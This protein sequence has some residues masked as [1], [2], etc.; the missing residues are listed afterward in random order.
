M[1]ALKKLSSESR[2][3]EAWQALSAAIDNEVGHQELEG[4]LDVLKRDEALRRSWGEYHLIGDAMRG[5]GPAQGDFM[6]RFSA[7]LA[8]E[9]TVLAPQRHVWP[10]RLAVASFAVVAVWGVV[11]MTGLMQDPA[12]PEMM[13]ERMPVAQEKLAIHDEAALAHYLIA[14]QEFAPMAVASPYQRAVVVV[15]EP[16]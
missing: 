13:V 6:Q 5:I 10:Q 4:C 2:L 1:S 14:H 8:D 11:S 3:D 12:A 7:T 15:A 16:R 9:P